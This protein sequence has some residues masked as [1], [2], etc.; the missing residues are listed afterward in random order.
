MNNFEQQPRRY[1]WILFDA[2]NTLFHFHDQLGLERLFSQYDH[3]LTTQEFSAYKAVNNALWQAYEQ[4]RITATELAEQRFSRW[5][6]RFGVTATELNRQFMH[7][8]AE[9]CV[10][11]PGVQTLLM[12]LNETVDMGIITNGFTLLQQ[13]RL[14]RYSLDQWFRFVVTSEEVG[15]AKPHTDIF[16]YAQQYM[17]GVLP[18]Q[19]LMVGDNPNSDIVGGNAVGFDTCWLNLDG[20]YEDGGIKATYEVT[21]WFDLQSLLIP[22]SQ[23]V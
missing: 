4:N 20:Q 9:V 2:D 1:K 8:M 17:T 15:V 12:N 23:P 14:R 7:V 10:P 21:S 13:A 11:M 6:S 19:V 5:A 16:T 22:A 18:S 3:R